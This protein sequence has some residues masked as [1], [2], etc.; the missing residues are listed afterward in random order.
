MAKILFLTSTL[1]YGG[2]TKI[3]VKIANYMSRFHE[4]MI[5][6]YGDKTVFYDIDEKV[7]VLWCAKTRCKVRKLRVIA[8]M[9]LVRKALHRL[10]PDLVVAFGNTE[11]LFAIVS[12]VGRRT[13]AVISERQDPYNYVPGKKNHMHMRYRLADGCVFQTDGA[14]KYFPKSVQDKS[15]VIPNFIEI[16]ETKPEDNNI[17]NKLIA[18]SARFELRQ[19]RQDIMV[20]AFSLVHKIHPE[21]KLCFYGDG[22]DQEKVREQ[23][24]KLGLSS[25]V[26]FAGQTKNIIENL[27]KSEIFVLTSDY[28]GI[29]NALME[30]MAVGLPVVS[31]DCSPGGARLL[32]KDGENGLLV[33][34]G[35]PV[36]I[37]DAICRFIEN[38]E[39]A[40]QCGENAREIIY[41]YSPDK[42]LNMWKVYLES[43]LT[44]DR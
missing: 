5:L 34:T 13:K 21:Y 39:F 33:P 32:I 26:V 12:S 38:P 1:G 19:K 15:I 30:A 2:A 27:K 35:D 17:K 41:K 36:S 7:N 9:L 8:Q 3:M 16:H 29:P 28:E 31:T 14:A 22:P 6:C 23:V 11:K 44:K 24:N 20:E 42:I 40:R 18:Y 37:S 25:F 4:T 43:F 10:N